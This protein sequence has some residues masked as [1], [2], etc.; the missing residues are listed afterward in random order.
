[1]LP[2]N[3]AAC[4]IVIPRCVIRVSG[5]DI[6]SLSHRNFN[7]DTQHLL[8]DFWRRRLPMLPEEMPSLQILARFKSWLSNNLP[9]GSNCIARSS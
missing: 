2:N 9:P 1:M 6:E 7:D 4:E 8:G 5:E 3:S